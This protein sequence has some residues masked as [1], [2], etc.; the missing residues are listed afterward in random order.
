MARLRFI[1]A[2]SFR[3][4][5]LLLAVTLLSMNYLHA[6]T[7]TGTILGT[8][9]DQSGAVLPR[10]S[11]TLRHVE[12][13]A[14]R[15]LTSDD[16]GR[17][18]APQLALGSYE[19]QAG[20]SGFGTEIR[21]GITITVGREAV[22]DFQLQ[23]GEV[24]QSIEVVGEAP[25][26][27]TGTSEIGGLVSA[28]QIQDL[29]LNG[30]DFTQLILLQP[31]IVH[32]RFSLQS[33]NTGSGAR[34]SAGG[35]RINYNNFMIDGT[36]KNDF[37]GTTT[38]S[39]AGVQLGVDA[40]QEFRVITHNYNAEFGQNA[41]AIITAVTRAGTNQMHGNWF[42]FHRNDNFDSPAYFDDGKKPEM[43]RNQF[44]GSLGGPIV[45]EK[46]FY[47]GAYEAFRERRGLTTTAFTPTQAVRDGQF[48]NSANG[49]LVPVDARI[50][51]F[52]NLYPVPNGAI[53]G[54]GTGEYIYTFKQPTNEDFFTTRV[55][56]RFADSDSM[57][58]RYQFSDADRADTRSAGVFADVTTSRQQ[59]LTVQ[60]T[61]IFSP[62]TVNSLT[63]SATRASPRLN[64][65]PQVPIDASL[66]TAPGLTISRITISGIEGG[67]AGS[68]GGTI[69]EFGPRNLDGGRWFTN[70]FQFKN[71][72]NHSRGEHSIKT[73]GYL[74]R[75]QYNIYQGDFN[76][77]MAFPT[78]TRFLQASPSRFTIEDPNSPR[79]WRQTTIGFYV[80]DDWKATRR[81]T[82]NLGLR[83][84]YATP[85]KDRWGRNAIIHDRLATTISVLDSMFEPGKKNFGPRVGFAW[86]VFGDAKTSIR[87]GAGIFHNFLVGRSDALG[88][89]RNQPFGGTIQADNPPF[90]SSLALASVAVS[91]LPRPSGWPR[92]L[93]VPTVYHYNLNIERQMAREIVVRA[94]YVGSGGRHLIGKVSGNTAYPVIQADGSKFF[95]AG[96]PFRNPVMGEILFYHSDANSFYNALELSLSRRTSSGLQFQ[97]SYTFSKALD[98]QSSL[99]GADNLQD[100][101]F[102]LDPDNIRSDRGR[103][104]ID[105]GNSFV[106][107]FGYELPLGAGKLL[108]G[109]QVNG[110]TTL[111]AGVPFTPIVGF[112]RSR[113][114]DARAPDRPNLAA[115]ASI[116]P[117][118]GGSLGCTLAAG[119][120]R[121]KVIAPG[122]ELRTP[123]MWFDPCAFSLPAV[124]TF[125][126][127]GRNTVEG[128]GI[129]VVDFSV[130]KNT[131]LTEGLRAEF[132]AEI[133]N[134]LH[135]DNFGLPEVQ[136]FDANGPYLPTVGRITS[137]ITTG[138]EI[139]FGLKFIF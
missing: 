51:P 91:G 125:G 64:S 132:R 10:A 74:E 35:A 56:H 80:Q 106:T 8:V 126:K 18:R 116:N 128:P 32:Q 135:R 66:A 37:G 68:A 14:A 26:V 119:D 30:R 105:T 118:S 87:G 123:V 27:Q 59:M 50:R 139:Q 86:D 16:A 113:N 110:I 93:S 23:I 115:G 71:D 1:F 138:R 22:V 49:Q 77:V 19:V 28:Q 53:L 12:T 104:T 33:P 107:N 101:G 69:T 100:G 134:L 47:F 122:T 15:T 6:Q 83:W 97:V 46:T 43:K 24:S 25:L 41:G 114:R 127:V 136:L 67:A 94:G 111:Q 40:I 109:W 60:E 61:H 55:D 20:V 76:G 31:G 7:S 62:S 103:S 90:P 78:L 121:Q 63:V 95:P 2:G 45:R 96:L 39:V 131:S 57:F 137:T 13:G 48:V 120:A 36:R 44:G 65:V 89:T 82:L 108:S 92:Q 130:V 11:I 124:G 34:I 133:F 70:T 42:Y 4:F 81:L 112:N 54:G 29:P 72:V 3:Q 21:K 17:Y 58:V 117:T 52:L 9:T 75:Q 129:A 79:A 99:A 73:G 38:G 85:H 102:V 5:A 98:D 84:E 88:L